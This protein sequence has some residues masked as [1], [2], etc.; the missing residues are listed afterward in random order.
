MKELQFKK[1]KL[2]NASKLRSKVYNLQNRNIGCADMLNGTI[3]KNR[4][5][6][7]GFFFCPSWAKKKCPNLLLLKSAHLGKKSAQN[8]ALLDP[9]G[10]IIEYHLGYEKTKMAFTKAIPVEEG[11][12]E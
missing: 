2:P 6:P 3:L 1:Q 7:T 11:E 8:G 10:S 9:S 5:R 4:V 12:G